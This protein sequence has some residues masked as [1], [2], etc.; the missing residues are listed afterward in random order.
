MRAWSVLRVT[1]LGNAV[2]RGVEGETTLN[3]ADERCLE[4][5][6]R[7]LSGEEDSLSDWLD[8]PLGSETTYVPLLLEQKERLLTER[9]SELRVKKAECES[10]RLRLAALERGVVRVPSCTA[11]SPTTPPRP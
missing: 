1:Y 9:E 11:R 3:P 10:L 8:E 7:W 4:M 5:L 2:E 6:R